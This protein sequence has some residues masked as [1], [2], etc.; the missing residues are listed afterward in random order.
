VKSVK[1]DVKESAIYIACIHVT[2][3]LRNQYRSNLESLILEKFKPLINIPQKYFPYR[4]DFNSEKK[5][6]IVTEPYPRTVVKITESSSDE[7]QDEEEDEDEEEVDQHEE[8]AQESC[9]K[10][11]DET[12]VLKITEPSSSD[13]QE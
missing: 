6:K 9:L 8:T 7:E 10:N 1:P 11:R 3:P 12:S 2:T 4:D 13:L 5:E